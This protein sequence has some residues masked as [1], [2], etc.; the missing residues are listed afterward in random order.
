MNRNDEFMKELDAGVPEIGDSIKKRCRRK[1][2][3][4]FLYQPL[5]G[6]AAVFLMFVLSVN[7]CAPVAKAF[8]NVP[9]LKEMTK[10]VAFSKSL[11][12]ALENDYVQGVYLTQTKDGVTIEITSMIVDK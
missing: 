12:S 11:K 3:K 8:S 6:M 7:L 4:Q 5:M 10:A 9:F 2:R 1:A